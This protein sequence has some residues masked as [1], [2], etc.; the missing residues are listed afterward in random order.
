M[1]IAL[2]GKIG[3][4]K[5]WLAEKLVKDNNYFQTSFAK[6]IKELAIELFEMNGK[7]RDLLVEFGEKMKTID[8]HVWIK[9]AMKE[10][11]GKTDV[12]LD[13]LRF[14]DEYT[15]LK[16][17]GWILVKIEIPE[18]ERVQNIHSKYGTEAPFHLKYSESFTENDLID[19][20][21]DLI[22]RNK[23]TMYEDLI[24]FLN[25]RTSVNSIYS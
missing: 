16:K 4:G 8:P 2:N 20:S 19:N 24:K 5:S 10:C 3:S 23:E 17:D 18:D 9:N 11:K 21:F 25:N 7:D 13:D 12:V 6:R 22:L 15:L 14:R 1:K